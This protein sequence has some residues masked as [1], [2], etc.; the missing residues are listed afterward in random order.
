[1]PTATRKTAAAPAAAKKSAAAATAAPRALLRATRADAAP[2][3]RQRRRRPRPCHHGREQEMGERHPAHLLL[4]QARRRRAGGLA[5]QPRRHRGRRQRLRRPGPSWA[6]ASASGGRRARGRDGAHRLRSA[7][8]AP[9]PTSGRDVL[10]T[11]SPQERT[12]NFGWA[13]TT[14]YG[15]DT[16]LH[17]IGHTLGLEHE[18]QNPNAGIS[19]NRAGRARLLQGTA[20]QLGRAAD[21]LEHPAQDPGVGDQGHDLGPGLGHGIPVRRRADRRAGEIQDRP[22]RPR[23]GSPTP[24]R[25]GWW[26]RIRACG[27]QRCRS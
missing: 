25:P 15:H 17:E 1:M 13:L 7:A 27:R 10:N 14:A 21:R 16:A 24:T 6:S 2:L 19:W 12:M 11:R 18:H 8:T 5:G 20:E 22:A 26:S 3:R 9:G 23:A 4:L